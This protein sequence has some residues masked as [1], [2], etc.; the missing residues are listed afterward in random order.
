[1]GY[2]NEYSI[3]QDG[4]VISKRKNREMKT[5]INKGTGYR[6][7]TLYNSNGV[8][9]HYSIHRLV[10]LNFIDNPNNYPM[11]DHINMDK[12]DNNKYNLRWVTCSANNRN[13]TFVKTHNLPRGVFKTSS[14]KYGSQIWRDKKKKYLGCF[15]TEEEAGNAYREQ[16]DS[17]MLEYEP[18]YLDR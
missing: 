11:C 4:V 14:G 7:I 16:Y 8:K 18:I 1:M 5:W 13:K 2:E 17:I 12:E 15:E 3:N 9:K 6:F 10:A